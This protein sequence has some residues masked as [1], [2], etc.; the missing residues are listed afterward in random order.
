MAD[1][2]TFVA[3]KLGALLNKRDF[4]NGERHKEGHSGRNKLKEIREDNERE[5]GRLQW[6]TG[7]LWIH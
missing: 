5:S 1:N 6:I 2:D 3:D 4:S 7:L